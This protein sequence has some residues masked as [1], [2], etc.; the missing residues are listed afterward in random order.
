MK[1]FPYVKVFFRLTLLSL[2][3]FSFNSANANLHFKQNADSPSLIGRWDMTLYINGNQY[4]S[5]LEVYLSGTRTL[6]GQYVGTG[7]SARPISKIN[8]ADGKMNF[9]IPPQWEKENNDISFEGTF[10][11]DSLKGTMVAADGK[12]YTWS[13]VRA[14][15]LKRNSEPVWQRPITIFNGKD[16][17]GWHASGKTNQWIVKDGVLTSPHSGFNLLTDKTFNDFKLHIEFRYPKGSN[18][19]VYLRGRYEVQIEDV[20]G[21][22]PYKDVFSAVYGFLPPSEIT[23]KPA[24]EW[25]SYDITLVGRMV[26]VVANGKTVICNREIPGITGGAINSHEGEPGPLL[27][28]G[29]H[30]P[31]EYR[32]IRITPAK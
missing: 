5:W 1:H 27:I 7:G 4:P 10:D 8:F 26:T 6:V 11:G 24:G 32:N 30:G 12:N 9:S 25:Q 16:L 19:G 3:F 29:D 31:I 18:S 15:S 17:S 23:A 13:A 28:Q 20:Q 22:E 21:D 14:P 2:F